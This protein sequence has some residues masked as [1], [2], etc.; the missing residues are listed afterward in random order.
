MGYFRDLGFEMS[1]RSNPTDYYMRI[2]NKEGITLE[3]I[4]RGLYAD[5][6][7]IK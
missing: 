5:E 3:F 6:I 7:T 2:M 4:D 1:W